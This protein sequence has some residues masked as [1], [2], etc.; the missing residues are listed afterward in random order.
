MQHKYK[1]SDVGGNQLTSKALRRHIVCPIVKRLCV[2]YQVSGGFLTQYQ[3]RRQ[4]MISEF[5]IVAQPSTVRRI[6]ASRNQR[7]FSPSLKDLS[8]RKFSLECSS[9]AHYL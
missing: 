3:N 9:I 1:V 6:V 2:I 5:V 8:R 7:T 4:K